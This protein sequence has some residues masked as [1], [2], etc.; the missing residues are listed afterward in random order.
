MRLPPKWFPAGPSKSSTGGSAEGGGGTGCSEGD[1]TSCDPINGRREKPDLQGASDAVR[2]WGHNCSGT[3]KWLLRLK[4]AP[5]YRE[6]HFAEKNKG[7]FDFQYLEI[8][9]ALGDHL[10]LQLRVC[11]GPVTNVVYRIE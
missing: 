10:P 11:S 6:A 8:I 1:S 4:S 2:V 3:V 9:D 7:Y 5:T